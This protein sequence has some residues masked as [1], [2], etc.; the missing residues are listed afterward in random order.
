MMPDEIMNM[1]NDDSQIV[2]MQETNPSLV[3]LIHYYQF[4][5]IFPPEDYDEWE[6]R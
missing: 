2:F 6:G 1:A 3:I 4:P 5:N